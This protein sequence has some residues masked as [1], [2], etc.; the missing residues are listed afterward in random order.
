[1]YR[2]YITRNKTDVENHG[3]IDGRI[4]QRM[5]NTGR[6]NTVGRVIS[7]KVQLRIMST[8]EGKGADD[9]HEGTEER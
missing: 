5:K 9:W 7:E 2:M 3:Y 6:L 4:W 8:G 1:M